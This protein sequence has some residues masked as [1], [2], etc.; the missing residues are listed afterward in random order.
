VLGFNGGGRLP[1]ILQAEASECG[2]VCLAMAASYYG[3][4]IDLN[5]LRSQHLLSLNGVTLKSLIDIARHLNLAARAVRLEPTDLNQLKLPAILHLDMN[6]FVVLKAVTKK[7]LAL[8][9]PATGV[10]HLSWSEA[11]KH[12]TGVAL[13]LTP[14]PQFERKDE[15]LRL[16]LASFLSQ[17]SGAKHALLQLLALS[18]ALEILVVAG[19]FYL[20]LTVDEVIARGD[21][22]LLTVL[23]L[24]FAL[25]AALTVAVNWLRSIIVIFIENTLH[26]AFGARLFHHL[27]RLPLSFFEKRH[28]GDLLSRF[29][30]IEPVRNLISE[31]LILALIDGVMAIFTL[32]IMFFYSVELALIVTATFAIYCAVRLVFFRYLRRLNEVAI[33]MKAKE[34]S[35]FVETLRG[36]QSIKVFNHEGQRES[37][38]LNR[39]ADSISAEVRLE[40][41]HTVFEAVNHLLF[42]AENI[43]II[44]LAARL[45]LDNVFTV[46][47]VF[48]FIS[49]TQQFISKANLLLDK[50]LDFG[51]VGLHLERL[52]DIALS[53][54]EPHHEKPQI[55]RGIRGS[56]ET[57]NISFRYSAS[58]D[59]VLQNINLVAGRGDFATIM[60]PSG[61]GK[62]TLLK[63]LLGLLEPTTGEVL[64]DGIPLRTL[65]VRAYRE[66][67]AAVMQDDHLLSGSIAENICFFSPH[68]DQEWMIKCAEMA[69]IHDEIEKMPMA[70]NSLVGD[71]G[72]SLSG[73]QKQ[74]I[75]LARALYRR[76][77]ILFL[78]EAT[79]HVDDENE[80]RISTNLQ[81][82]NITRISI[83]HRSV[84]AEGADLVLHLA[85]E[86][87]VPQVGA[88][89]APSRALAV[90][91]PAEKLRVRRSR[92]RKWQKLRA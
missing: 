65:G 39:F 66:Q 89:L 11:C 60:G 41:I 75:L 46:G 86:T 70:Y 79:A 30:S 77:S 58:D 68:I 63:I 59:F 18:L 48:A 5:T 57:R 24:G 4:Q 25:I 56:V 91:S 73:G 26:F 55:R 34:T 80:R 29:T 13:E 37:L 88:A 21:V 16:K 81:A 47:M 82:L 7:G 71:M 3:H 12:L 53:P 64:I 27:I 87:T 49:Y 2:L 28:V 83:A 14:T 35:N 15:R 8:H 84:L 44:Y 61:C 9:D 92:W 20:Q 50:A 72:S 45:T 54:I 51:I 23:A 32:V 17:A 38:W 74:R 36:I 31:G 78:D 42:G 69:C 33:Q 22:D 43:I 10:Q 76:P 67:V 19:P 85:S 62:T 1:V 40:R 90:F 52:S 6:H